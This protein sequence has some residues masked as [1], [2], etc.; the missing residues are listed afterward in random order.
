MR[1]V[2]FKTK[3]CRRWRKLSALLRVE[4]FLLG[5]GFY[6]G[7]QTIRTCW[8]HYGELDSRGSDQTAVRVRVCRDGTLLEPAEPLPPLSTEFLA[9]LLHHAWGEEGAGGSAEH[10]PGEHRPALQWWVL[11]VWCWFYFILF[12][13]KTISNLKSSLA[14]TE[15]EKMEYLIFMRHRNRKLLNN[16][17]IFKS[18]ILKLEFIL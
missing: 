12:Y 9:G 16:S 10:F 18:Y 17:L 13:F 3:V 11:T 15:S 8:Y 2:S 4:M 6:F 14:L 1:G 7:N 5:W